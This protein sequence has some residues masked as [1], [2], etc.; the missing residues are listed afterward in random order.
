MLGNGSLVDINPSG[1]NIQLDLPIFGRSI[2]IQ[3][4]V[5]VL[6]GL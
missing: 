3:V 4:S 2:H 1:F 5:G 6:L